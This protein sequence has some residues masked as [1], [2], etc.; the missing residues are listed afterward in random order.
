M[1]SEIAQLFDSNAVLGS[2]KHDETFQR[3]IPY[4]CQKFRSIIAAPKLKPGRPIKI[5]F[6]KFFEA[7][8]FLCKSGAQTRC[9]PKHFGIPCS[10]FARYFKILK[11]SGLLESINTTVL[12]ETEMPNVIT[13][14]T[15]TVKS[16]D[17]SEGTGK[18]P[19]DRGRKGIKVSLISDSKKRIRRVEY[20][21]ANIHDSNLL[22]KTLRAPFGKRVRCFA[23]SAYI[24]SRVAQH[25]KQHNVRMVAQPRRTLGS[26]KTHRLSTKDRKEM[27]LYRNATEHNNG[28][29]R[30]FRG[31]HNKWVKT[32]SSYICFVS[33]AVLC[34]NC[35]LVYVKS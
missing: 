16:M 34:I 22:I 19:T 23:D 27:K 15:F 31:I 26:N 12:S 13:T 30:R 2:N 5:D 32:M 11:H 9:I 8:H 20:D 18:N 14:D 24:G 28:W 4:L 25:C 21:A 35:Y 10:T 3:L 1:V 7:V 6:S 33:L 17:G 29:L